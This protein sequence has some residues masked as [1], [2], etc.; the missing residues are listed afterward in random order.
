MS[1][2]A[3]VVVAAAIGMSSLLLLLLRNSSLLLK[4]NESDELETFA[5]MAVMRHK[6]PS[7]RFEAIV[8]K[9]AAGLTFAGGVAVA[10]DVA[11]E[12]AERNSEYVDTEI[13]SHPMLSYD[14]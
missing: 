14:F 12:A 4:E 1:A 2:A 13:R 11:V 7:T 3:V 6:A 8:W 5:M 10:D 9:L